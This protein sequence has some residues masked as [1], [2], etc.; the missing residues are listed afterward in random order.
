[1][2]PGCTLGGAASV[3]HIRRQDVH[4]MPQTESNEHEGWLFKSLTGAA[5]AGHAAG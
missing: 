4:H 5:D 1:M 2:R 3:P